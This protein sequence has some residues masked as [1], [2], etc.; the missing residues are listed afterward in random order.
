MVL[1][2][3]LTPALS[4]EERENHSPVIRNFLPLD[5]YIC[6]SRNKNPAICVLSLGRGNR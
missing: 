2:L 3:A 4:P 5:W 1:T 6:H